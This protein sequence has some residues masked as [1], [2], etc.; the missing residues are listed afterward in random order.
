MAS[1]ALDAGAGRLDRGRSRLLVR[2]APDAFFA[3]YND[4]AYARAPG[5]RRE[6]PKP[7]VGLFDWEAEV[8][9]K[10]FPPPPASILVGA[11]GAGREAIALGARGYTVTSFEPSNALA[12]SHARNAAGR[13]CLGRYEELPLVEPVSGGGRVDLRRDAPFA[14]G[15]CGW[16]SLSHLRT[17]AQRVEALRAMRALVDGPL[18]VSYYAAP[19]AGSPPGHGRDWFSLD[20]GFIHEFDEREMAALAVEAGWTVAAS[21]HAG[22]WP[23]AVLQRR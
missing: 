21:H 14:A 18:L 23:H 10:G 6:A 15:I 2:Y 5:Y 4:L 13:V 1:G 8:V 11:A 20:L 12:A 16:S 3:T 17:A 7:R 9:G 22:A 19:P